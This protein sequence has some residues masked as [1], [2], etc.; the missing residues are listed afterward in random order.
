[1]RKLVHA[2]RTLWAFVHPRRPRKCPAIYGSDQNFE[3]GKAS[4][5]WKLRRYSDRDRPPRRR[6][7]P[8]IGTL[9]AEDLRRVLDL[10]T[11][12]PLD[13]DAIWKA[14]K[15]TGSDRGRRRASHRLRPRSRVAQIVA[16]THPAIMNLSYA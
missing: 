9:E 1:M 13:R 12:K 2:R 5:S 8:R 11:I 10:H 3:I 6:I 15:E 7:D 16:E 4:N 14:A